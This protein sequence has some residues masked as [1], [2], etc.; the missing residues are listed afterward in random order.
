MTNEE[1]LHIHEHRPALG[2]ECIV[3][4]GFLKMPSFVA[5]GGM[6]CRCNLTDL[7]SECV[8]RGFMKQDDEFLFYSSSHAMKMLYPVAFQDE[9]AISVQDYL[10]VSLPGFVVLSI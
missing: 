8:Q 10:A 7:R 3:P 2:S 6:K 4:T 9:T 1:Y 5:R